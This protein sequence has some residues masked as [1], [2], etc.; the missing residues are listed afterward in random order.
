MQRPRFRAS[1]PFPGFPSMNRMAIRFGWIKLL[2]GVVALAQVLGGC[3]TPAPKLADKNAAL[4]LLHTCY[5]GLVEDPVLA[6][7]KAKV[8]LG[9]FDRQTAAMLADRTMPSETERP[10]IKQWSEK[11]VPCA[12]DYIAFFERFMPPPTRY[13]AR[14]AAHTEQG[15][16]ASLAEGKLSYGDFARERKENKERQAGPQYRP[17]VPNSFYGQQTATICLPIESM[18]TSCFTY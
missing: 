6:P 9:A 18:T 15:L 1:G 5:A 2:G 11:R 4:A 8:S 17:S 12:N 13:P 10:A 3:A 7:I 14:M 16:I